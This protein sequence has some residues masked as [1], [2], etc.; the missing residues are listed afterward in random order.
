MTMPNFLIIGA[1]KA[2]TSS[3]YQYLKQHPQIYMSP[4][5]ETNFFALEG[6]DLN[7]A[8][9]RDRINKYSITKIEDYY[10]Q[11]EAVSNETAIGE[12]SPLYLYEPKAPEQIQHYIPDVKLIAIL[13]NPVDR[14]YAS[15]LYLHRE[16]RESLEYFSEALDA[17][18]SR[19]QNNYPWIWHYKNLGFYA[20]QLQRYFE[21]KNLTESKSK[22]ICMKISR[23]IIWRF[24]KIYFSF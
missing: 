2:G 15:F 16:Q 1:G 8:D 14:A 13:R 18:P 24:C 11:F 19:I 7:F 9:P 6:Q 23:R 22:F 10:A 12:A 3:L 20:E 17:E 4:I 5:K 21:K